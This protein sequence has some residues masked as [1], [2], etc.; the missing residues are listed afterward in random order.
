RVLRTDAPVDRPA[1]RSAQP[2]STRIPDHDSQTGEGPLMEETHVH[3]LDYLSVFR[4]RKWWLVLP[5]VASIVIGAALV[6]FLP[7]QY[8]ASATVAVVAPAVSPNLVGQQAP[9][10]NEERFRAVSQQLLSQA[11]L[12]RVAREEALSTGVPDDLLLARIRSSVSVGIP[13][14]VAVTNEPRRFDTFI[15]SYSDADPAR[16]QRVANRLAKVF[17]DENSKGRE[18]RAEHTATFIQSELASSQTR[19]N[20]LEARLRRAKESHIGQLPEQTTANLQTLSGLRT[21]LDA[22]A[23]ALRGEQDRLSMIE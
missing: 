16:A 22:H 21:Q 19:L 7:K 5:I 14:P 11:V 3:A 9:L 2:Q 8:K 4:R 18:Q 1:G 10:D 13:E 23:T 15:V 17:V 12:S 20:D 6:R